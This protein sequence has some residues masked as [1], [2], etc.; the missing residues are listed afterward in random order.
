MSRKVL[1]IGS[2]RTV[3]V[4]SPKNPGMIRLWLKVGLREQR[5]GGQL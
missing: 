1:G 4:E 2:N 5:S 3:G